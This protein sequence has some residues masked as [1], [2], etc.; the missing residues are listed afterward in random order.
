[1]FDEWIRS[2][3]G[4]VFIQGF[5]AA[6][7][8][9]MGFEPPVCVFGETCGRALIIEHNGDIYSCDHFVTPE[10]KLGNLTQTP[11]KQLVDSA[12]QQQFALRKRDARPDECKRC[13]F[14]FACHGACP[15]DRV[16]GANH[17]CAGYKR[18]FEHIN[19]YME[20]MAEA[21]R[22]GQ[23]AAVVMEQ[24]RERPAVKKGRRRTAETRRR[25]AGVRKQAT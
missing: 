8:A 11:L 16:G 22:C 17:L 18:F 2:D 24:F 14:D 13:R 1:V 9:W 12:A 21:L 19:P 6:L 3:V 4:T 5:D 23:P 20:Q 7:A 10:H 15:K 25:R